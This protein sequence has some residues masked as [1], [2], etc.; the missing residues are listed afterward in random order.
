MLTALAPFGGPAGGRPGGPGVAANAETPADADAM[1]VRGPRPGRGLPFFGP[2]VIEHERGVYRY[3]G[4]EVTV[5]YG[6]ERLPIEAEPEVLQCGPYALQVPNDVGPH[7][8]V[9][10]F[11]RA[12]GEWLLFELQSDAVEICPLVEEFI[13]Q[14]EFFLEALPPDTREAPFPAVLQAD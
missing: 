2:N 1:L 7:R 4:T 3:R 13:E 8:R 14:F 5:Y 11:E 9:F 6:E 12:A 10:R